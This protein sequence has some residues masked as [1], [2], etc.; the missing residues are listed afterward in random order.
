MH[1]SRHCH[2][3]NQRAGTLC[4]NTVKKGHE[5]RHF[6]VINSSRVRYV[7]RNTKTFVICTEVHITGQQCAR[8]LCVKKMVNY[9]DNLKRH[10]VRPVTVILSAACL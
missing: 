1:G 7:P 6:T 9:Y 5:V 8:R 2:G 4:V 10:T 3:D